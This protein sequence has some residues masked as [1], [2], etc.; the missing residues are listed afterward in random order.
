MIV[1]QCENC[2]K[3]G[4]NV[5]CKDCVKVADSFDVYEYRSG[6]N[7]FNKGRSICSIEAYTWHDAIEYVRNKF[8]QVDE[9]SNIITNCEKDFAYLEQKTRSTSSGN[10]NNA[11]ERDLPSYKIYLNNGHK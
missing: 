8:F 4:K 1:Q 11:E 2:N 3:K 7:R 6:D 10:D 9:K 5:Y